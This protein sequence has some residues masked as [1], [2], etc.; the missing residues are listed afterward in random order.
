MEYLSNSIQLSN[1]TQSIRE[2]KI[3][4]GDEIEELV[5]KIIKIKHIKNS[6]AI[7]ETLEKILNKRNR[8][9]KYK[10]TLSKLY[11][12][13]IDLSNEEHKELLFSIWTHFKKDEPIELVDRKWS[14]ILIY[15]IIYSNSECWLSRERPSN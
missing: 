4:S 12:E 8:L 13:Q 5:K 6:E 2:G 14:N 7:S 10:S 1:L 11:Q 15:L 9:L 3:L